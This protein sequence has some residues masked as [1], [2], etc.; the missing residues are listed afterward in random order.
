[1]YTRAIGCGARFLLVP[2]V[3]YVAVVRSDSLSERHRAEDLLHLRNCDRELGQLAG[4]SDSN[5][6]ALRQHAVSVDCR[7][8]WRLL[9]DALK[10]RR[11][12]AVLASFAQPWPVPWYLA[13]RLLERALRRISGT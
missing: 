6:A 8:Q 3:G 4:L 7:L 12:G 10:Q 9:I 1:L 2:G 5:R 13:H 11:L